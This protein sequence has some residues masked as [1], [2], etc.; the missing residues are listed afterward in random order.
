MTDASPA[1]LPSTPAER[2]A[3]TLS[4]L[5]IRNI[6][7]IAT[8]VLAFYLLSLLRGV[9][10]LFLA[11]MVI[12]FL[13]FPLVQWMGQMPLGRGRRLGAG[14]SILII[15]L[16]MGG[17]L[18]LTLVLT[19]GLIQEQTRLL[20]SAIETG[21]IA[22]QLTALKDLVLLKAEPLAKVNLVKLDELE[23]QLI[24]IETHYIDELKNWLKNIDLQAFASQ[25]FGGAGQVIAVAV[26]LPILVFYMIVDGPTIKRT[27]LSYVP[28]AFQPNALDF[29]QNLERTLNSYLRGQIKLGF[30]IFIL[31]AILLLIF[32]PEVSAWLLISLVAGVTEII[33][34]VGP[35]IALIVALM[36]AGIETGG[37]LAVLGKIVLIFTGVQMIENQ[38]LVPRIMGKQLDVH[39]LTVM[40]FLLAGSVLGGITGALLSLPIAATLKVLMDQYYPAFIRRVQALLTDDDRAVSDVLPLEEQ[41]DP[42]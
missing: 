20:L 17:F 35:T 1:P 9:I 39:P 36:V 5:N 13:L 2:G 22:K 31:D 28:P 8:V 25:L 11:A 4:I 18:T 14:P 38:L 3:E 12:A 16:V 34:V 32:V 15:Y 40:F 23:E 21:T 29:L 26:M 19:S 41:P 42:A 27:L 24:W 30:S 7:T 10:A 6:L 37:N 33:P